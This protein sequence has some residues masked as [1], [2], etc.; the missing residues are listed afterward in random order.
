MHLLWL[1]RRQKREKSGGRERRQSRSNNL[2]PSHPTAVADQIS[3]EPCDVRLQLTTNKI[4]HHPDAIVCL[5]NMPTYC[6]YKMCPH[7]DRPLLITWYSMILKQI[8]CAQWL[9]AAVEEPKSWR[10]INA[11][12]T[13]HNLESKRIIDY[14]V[15]EKTLSCSC[16][17]WNTKVTPIDHKKT[18]KEQ[19]RPDPSFRATAKATA[20]SLSLSLSLSIYLYLS[21]SPAAW[22]APKRLGRWRSLGPSARRLPEA[23]CSLIFFVIWYISWCKK[24]KK[25]TKKNVRLS[26][27]P[28]GYT[29]S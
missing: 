2:I 24:Q 28:A 25:K 26:Y 20:I 13:R 29:F 6:S 23:C 8:N 17:V 9:I 21:L 12:A 27:P 22:S 10:E 7:R 16:L 11:T 19:A 3:S 5:L 4:Q 14:I 18:C 15:R 1:P